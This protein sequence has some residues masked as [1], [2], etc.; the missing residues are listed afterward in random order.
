MIVTKVNSDAETLNSS[1]L[2]EKLNRKQADL[3]LRIKEL[4]S[5]IDDS[6]KSAY[7][8]HKVIT[9]D[10]NPRLSRTQIAELR[11]TTLKN[12]ITFVFALLL[13]GT[14]TYLLYIAL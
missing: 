10:N 7:H 11:S 9:T 8:E 4:E 3:N 14:V 5:L 1:K 13:F 2:S 6:P 12:F